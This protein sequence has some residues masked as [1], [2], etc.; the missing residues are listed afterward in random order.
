MAKIVSTTQTNSVEVASLAEAKL[1][2]ETLGKYGIKIGVQA[3]ST[4]I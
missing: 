3:L 4:A 2:Q 1:L